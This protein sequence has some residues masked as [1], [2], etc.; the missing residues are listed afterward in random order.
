MHTRC[1]A[2]GSLFLG[3]VQF[4]SLIANAAPIP[5][6]G[7]G[8]NGSGRLFP[9]GAAGALVEAFKTSQLGNSQFS[10]SRNG[11]PCNAVSQADIGEDGEEESGDND[12][13]TRL[14]TGTLDR[15][16]FVDEDGTE[17]IVISGE[18]YNEESSD[19]ADVA[20]G[21]EADI[22]DEDSMQEFRSSDRSAVCTKNGFPCWAFPEGSQ[23]ELNI[24][25]TSSCT[26]NGI[27]CE[28]FVEEEDGDATFTLR[29]N[30]DSYKTCTRNNMP[31]EEYDRLLAEGLI[32]V[33][34]N[35]YHISTG[36]ENARS[37][38]NDENDYEVVNGGN[39][40]PQNNDSTQ[41]GKGKP[42]SRPLR[43]NSY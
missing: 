7:W 36:S 6:P 29:K 42:G 10:C 5:N 19:F 9:G 12:G 35:D 34:Q 37:E 25:R 8:P 15:E 13:V 23:R 20:F 11:L 41:R 32:P 40:S 30:N 22:D 33:T 18:I 39:T 2:S 26:R 27:P 31:C 17:K 24:E 21:E 14:S 4:L 43:I 1:L 3:V 28:E 16:E 38:V